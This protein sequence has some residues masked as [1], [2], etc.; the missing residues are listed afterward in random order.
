LALPE[1]AVLRAPDGDWQV[2]V[3]EDEATF[4]PVE[5][6]PLRSAGGLTVITGLPAGT[7]VVTQ[8]AFFLQSELAKGGFDPHNH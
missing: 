3:A 4:R 2:F 5:V 1:T 7:R 8:G 6:V